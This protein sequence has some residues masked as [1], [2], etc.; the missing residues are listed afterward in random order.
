M[1]FWMKYRLLRPNWMVPAPDVLQNL[2][3]LPVVNLPALTKS[4][5][6]LV[7][8]PHPDDET[9]GCGGLIAQCCARG[10][11]IHVLVLTDGAASHPRSASYPAS[12]LVA[13]RRAETTAAMAT[14]GLPAE[15]LGFLDLPDG[16]APRRGGRLRDAAKRIADMAQRFSAATIC[17]TWVHDPHCDH[18][19]AYRLGALAARMLGARLLCYPVWGWTLGEQKWL[20]RTPIHGMRL[21]ISDH[22]AAKRKAIACYRS[23]IGDLIDDDPSG[24]RLAPE[25]L[26]L[27]ERPFEVFVEEAAAV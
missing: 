27:F 22:I 18:V 2:L 25:F 7:L 20:M 26:A 9:L 17:T 14:L 15:R 5:S 3:H 16:R 21:D 24:F 13:L 19:A 12:R 6:V 8:A 11:N 1:R 4:G 23:Q 10:Q